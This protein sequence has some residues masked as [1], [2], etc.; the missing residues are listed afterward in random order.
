MTQGQGNIVQTFHQRPAHVVIDLKSAGEITEARGLIFQRNRDLCAWISFEQFP[1]LFT[2]V[3]AD[4]PS[5]EAL[6][7]RVSAE[8]IGELGRED[9][10][11]AVVAKCPH[12]ML[13][14]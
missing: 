14:R 5:N 12:R 3:L 1:E 8:N 11:K 2:V 4:D 13:A 7:A 6:L 10:L 9:D